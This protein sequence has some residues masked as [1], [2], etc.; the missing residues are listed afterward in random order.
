M[1]NAE[2]HKPVE[3]IGLGKKFGDVVAVEAIDFAVERGRVI[4]LLGGNGAGKTTTMS[5]LMGLLTPTSG[6]AKIFGKDASI[7]DASALC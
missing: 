7:R 2:A 3:V 5:M 4:G 1:S 6:I